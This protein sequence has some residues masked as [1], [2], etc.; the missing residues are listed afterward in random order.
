MNTYFCNIVKTCD[1]VC[2]MDTNNVSTNIE[3]RFVTLIE[4]DVK[5]F[6]TDIDVNK[7]SSI[8]HLNSRVL[9]DAFLY[10]L[11]QLT[12]LFNCSL[13]TNIFPT[14]WKYGKVV[15]I[16]KTK[17]K[18]YVTN[19][20]P[21]CLLSLPGK[22]L[23]KLV[24][25]QLYCFLSQ[26][27]ILS[28]LQH[29]FSSGKSTSTALQDFMLYGASNINNHR[30]CSTHFI[31]LSKAF[32]SLNHTI[33][34]EK[35]QKYGLKNHS[36]LW[37]ESYLQ[38][39]KQ[40]T[41]FNGIESDLSCISQGVPQGSTLGPLLYMVY[42]NNCFEIITDD[43][44]MSTI[45]MYADDTVLISS[46][47]NYKSAMDENQS[48]FER[49]INWTSRN[50]LQINVT[51][52]KHMLLSSKS[53]SIVPDV[54]IIKDNLLIHNTHMYTY[55]GCNLDSNLSL[56]LF[57]KDIVRRV[58]FKL[59]L[60]GKIRYLLTFDAAVTV[61]KQMVLPFFDYLDIMIEGCIKKHVDK[62]QA[63]QFRGIKIIYQYIY[64]GRKITSKDESVLHA[65]L[66]LLT[67][68]NRRKKHLLNMMYNL[69]TRRPE[70]LAEHRGSMILRSNQ[71]ILFNEDR[72]NSEIYRKSP[73]VG[74]NKLWKQLSSD[75]QRVKT[76]TE[77]SRLLTDDIISQLEN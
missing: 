6:V 67:L 29:G 42:V 26:N 5:K 59:Y 7:S 68:E 71:C 14:E 30:Y 74:G 47:E 69:K 34:L 63:L 77:F 11:P 44:E 41:L 13:G 27:R 8:T 45:L 64:T 50:G 38:G 52:T 33:L 37:F 57:V 9:K 2:H 76:K 23:E 73:L 3:F 65:E 22:I 4:K 54:N 15:P 62:L 43:A 53:K 48:L 19:W 61:Y 72:I 18:R 24:H 10:L 39:R 25:R 20:R 46:G 28:K 58:N 49:Y 35:L 40:Q 66:G 21:I 32:D 60:F 16:P 56:D 75:I 1:P 51:K 55:L 12:H 17:Q 36:G 31:D 70:L